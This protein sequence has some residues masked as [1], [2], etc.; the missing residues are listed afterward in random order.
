M[1][2]PS[3]IPPPTVHVDD[4]AVPYME[5]LTLSE[6]TRIVE[7]NFIGG[8][9]PQAVIDGGVGT[10]ITVDDPGGEIR[11]FRI[12]GDAR[13]IQANDSVTI[14]NNVF[15]EGTRPP[16]PNTSFATVEVTGAS[17]S[18]TVNGNIFSDPSPTDDQWG[19]SAF[20]AGTLTLHDNTL[21]GYRFPVSAFG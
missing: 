14:A 5:N 2:T 20:S 10:A 19:I 3:D 11:G 12:R 9:E 6:N 8:D 17:T 18:A 7:E 15:D 13:A 1:A 21:T 16:E 4:D